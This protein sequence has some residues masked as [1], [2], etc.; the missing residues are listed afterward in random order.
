LGAEKR[1]QEPETG[2]ATWVR[3]LIVDFEINPLRSAK[4]AGRIED[5]PTKD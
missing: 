4:L 2:L 1:R 3:K 5:H